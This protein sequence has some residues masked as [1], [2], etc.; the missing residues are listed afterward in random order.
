MS[1]AVEEFSAKAQEQQAIIDSVD[2]RLP[3]AREAFDAAV[4]TLEVFE[5]DNSLTPDDRTQF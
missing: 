2:E 3:A 5:Q 4:E 1:A